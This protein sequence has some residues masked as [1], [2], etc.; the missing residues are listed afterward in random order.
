MWKCCRII[1]YLREHGIQA[2]ERKKYSEK[3]KKVVGSAIEIRKRP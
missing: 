1:N 3:R 2:S